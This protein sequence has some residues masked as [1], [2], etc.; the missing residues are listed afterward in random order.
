MFDNIRGSSAAPSPY[1]SEA[2]DQAPAPSDV[3]YESR[4]SPNDQFSSLNPRQDAVSEFGSVVSGELFG[5]YHAPYFQDPSVYSQWSAGRRPR[6]ESSGGSYGSADD[7]SFGE[8][9]SA[10]SEAGSHLPPSSTSSSNI[11]SLHPLSD[12]SQALSEAGSRRSSGGHLSSHSSDRSL[13]DHQNRLQSVSDGSAQRSLTG[14]E[15][16]AI[17]AARQG[18]RFLSGDSELGS[19]ASGVGYDGGRFGRRGET[20]GSDN[21]TGFLHSIAENLSEAGS[22]SVS[23]ERAELLERLNRAREGIFIPAD[24]PSASWQPDIELSVSD[25]NLS[26]TVTE[27]GPPT[28]RP[29]PPPSRLRHEGYPQS[30]SSAAAS[31]VQ[32]SVPP[33]LRGPAVYGRQPAV[34][35][36]WSALT[37]RR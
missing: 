5:N 13:N 9:S 28:R 30:D 19:V 12:V 29:P 6:S 31:S 4:R 25:L 10:G 23:P 27:A 1:Y 35:R 7:R 22:G 24:L 11:S 37:K 16:D 36:A 34:S 2:N 14:S 26:T 15:L 3:S 18:G 8:R 33:R 32:S 17:Q 21:G 20:H